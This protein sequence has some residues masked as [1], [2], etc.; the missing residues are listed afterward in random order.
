MPGERG[1]CEVRVHSDSRFL[2]FLPEAQG[3]VGGRL[4]LSGASIALFPQKVLARILPQ[5]PCVLMVCNDPRQSQETASGGPKIPGSATLAGWG[6]SGTGPLSRED[7]R[8]SWEMGFPSSSEPLL[9]PSKPGILVLSY[10][11]L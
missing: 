3:E 9:L 5:G 7:L 8:L 6:R 4:T 2:R 1:T 10:L 11:S